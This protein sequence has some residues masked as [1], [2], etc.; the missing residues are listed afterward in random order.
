MSRR[1]AVL[2][3]LFGHSRLQV[4][5]GGPLATARSTSTAGEKDTLAVRM[6][7]NEVVHVGEE[8]QWLGTDDNYGYGLDYH[9]RRGREKSEGLQEQI[10]KELATRGYARRRKSSL[11]S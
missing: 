3:D 2:E 9:S 6:E 5:G 10:E 4:R 1:Q 8:R 7:V 11:Q